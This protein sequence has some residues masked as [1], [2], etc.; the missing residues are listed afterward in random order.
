MTRMKKLFKIFRK[1][2]FLRNLFQSQF[3]NG[4]NKDTLWKSNDI[5]SFNKVFLK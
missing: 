4:K 2:N 3:Y 5:I 1:P